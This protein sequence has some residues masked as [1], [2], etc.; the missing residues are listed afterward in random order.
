[1]YIGLFRDGTMRVLEELDPNN[2]DPELLRD[3]REV[4]QVSKVLEPVVVL[5]PKPKEAR[6]KIVVEKSSQ[7][8][9]PGASS[10]SK[11]PKSRKKVS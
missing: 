7:E 5:R 1:M 9:E 4:Y 8:Q 2:P 10:T 11:R 6:Q 3:I